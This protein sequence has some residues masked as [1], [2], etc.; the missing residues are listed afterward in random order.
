MPKTFEHL[1]RILD[2]RDV[3]QACTVLLLVL[4][5]AIIE[6]VGIVSI[7]PFLAVLA[8]PDIINTNHYLA[9]LY[10]AVG[11]ESR[12]DFLFLLGTATFVLLVGSSVL[13]GVTIWAQLRFTFLQTHAIGI[14]LLSCYLQQPYHWF[15]NRHSSDFSVKVLHEVTNVVQNVLTP[16]ML[17]V[18]NAASVTLIL[19]ILVVVDPLLAT[20]AVAILGVVYSAVFIFTKRRLEVIGKERLEANQQRYKA[21]HEVLSVIKYVKLSEM[22]TRFAERFRILS[23]RLARRGIVGAVVAELPSLFMQGLIFGGMLL[24]LLY[25]INAHGSVGMALPVVGVYAIA[26]YRLMPALQGIYKSLSQIRFSLPSLDTLRLDLNQLEVRTPSTVTNIPNPHVPVGM[27]LR[28]RLEL[29]EMSFTYPGATHPALQTVNLIVCESTTIGVVG[30]SGAGKT[31]FID[32]LLGLLTPTS[33][34]ILVDGVVVDH[35]NVRVWQRGVGYVPQNIHLLDDTIALNIAF[36]CY[37]EEVDMAAVE[38]VAR[39]ANLHDFIEKDLPQGYDTVVGEQ[40]VRLSGGERQRIGI[41]RALYHDPSVLVFDEATSALD[42]LTESVVMEA[43][44]T[45]GRRKTIIIVAHRL[46]TVRNC[47]RI[48]VLDRGTIVAD[49]T[50]DQLLEGSEHFRSMVQAAGEP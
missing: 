30:T 4:V 3:R 11:F 48:L 28:D 18:A 21:V 10:K 49:G 17:L 38:R 36:G 1:L 14:R 39:I 15:F 12:A 37:R 27:I 45:L 2:P 50:Y 31:T 44:H 47:D 46:S 5:M 6:S 20:S 19:I 32:L 7:M 29:R 24:V 34:R 13:R 35:H 43:M 42:N 23:E 16:A 26:G 22:E 9:S 40:G 41:A 8:N 25:L 33:G